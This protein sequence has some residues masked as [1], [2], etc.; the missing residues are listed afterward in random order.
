[1]IARGFPSSAAPRQ[2]VHGCQVPLC[3]QLLENKQ[4]PLKDAAAAEWRE[5][6]A[7]VC[8]LEKMERREVREAG[9]EYGKEDDREGRERALG[10]LRERE[11]ERD[12]GKKSSQSP[13]SL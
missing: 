3:F 11:G 13:S 10:C 8:E 4:K 9:D 12:R 1:M 6:I 2:N 5:K 7:R